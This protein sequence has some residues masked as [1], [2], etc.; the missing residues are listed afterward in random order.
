MSNVLPT[1]LN[2]FVPILAIG[3]V[4]VVLVV[5]SFSLRRRRPAEATDKLEELFLKIREEIK[6]AVAPKF[7]ELSLG[8]NDLVELAVEVWRMEQRIAKAESVLSE[9]HKN[10]LGN[11]IQ[12][13]RRYLQK[14]DIEIVDYT[15]QKF[16]VGLNFE[17]LSVEK[18]P[19]V[20]GSVVKETIEPTIMYKGQVVH[21]AK[22]I[23][24][25]NQ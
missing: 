15:N 21:K 24:L 18:G 5:L 23:L 19:S 16:N 13:L 17:I 6:F 20:Q 10:G 4:I 3:V 25:T 9:N 1:N 22:I 14:Y 2:S 7:M 12:K 8:M 11:S